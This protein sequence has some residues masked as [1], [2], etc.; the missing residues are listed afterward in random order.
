MSVA[1]KYHLRPPAAAFLIPSAAE[2]APPQTKTA[3]DSPLREAALK[4]L[5]GGTAGA[6]AMVANVGL[7]MWLR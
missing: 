6:A 3:K 1:P 2:A 4:A 7:L 5:G